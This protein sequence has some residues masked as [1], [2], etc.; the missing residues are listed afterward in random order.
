[1]NIHIS[2]IAEE[3]FK[4][5]GLGITNSLLTAF[6]GF[7]LLVIFIVVLRSKLNAYKPGKM[8]LMTEMIYVTLNKLV[9]DI[10][11]AETAKKFIAFLLTFFI[12]ILS[13][14]W[15]GLL[16]IVPSLGIIR[17]EEHASETAAETVETGEATNQNSGVTPAE[18]QETEEVVEETGF[19]Y[20]ENKICL[21]TGSC[22]LSTAG[23]VENVEFKPVFRAATADLSQTLALALIS[24]I[25][26]NLIGLKTGGTKFL[27]RY[28]DTRG[29]INLFVS[30]LELI[31]EFGKIISFSFRLFGNV[32][33]GE[34][35]LTVITALTFGIVSM[36]F[37][38]L[39]L[40]VGAIQAIVFFMLTAVFI[41]LAREHH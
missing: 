13:S 22:Y 9:E 7:I 2:F 41:S 24:V 10:M 28:F 1:M 4:I 20:S 14:N 36:P 31:S 17:P 8:E 6:A 40:F 27:Q 34:V 5:G 19:K 16:P 33:A 23:I 12:L 3:I 26:T 38:G 25:V 32:F 15:L 11:G 18:T 29:P 37:L 30:I 35:L 21:L 39:E